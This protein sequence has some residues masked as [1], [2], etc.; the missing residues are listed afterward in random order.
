MLPGWY[1]GSLMATAL[2]YLSSARI[3]DLSHLSIMGTAT[4][5]RRVIIIP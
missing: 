1:I 2:A 3:D 4:A 5:L